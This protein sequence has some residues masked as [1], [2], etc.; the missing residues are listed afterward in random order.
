MIKT[1]RYP[2]LFIVGAPKSGT[3]SMAKYLST[4]PNIYAPL[5]KEFTYFG[6]DLVKYATIIEERQYLRWFEPWNDQYF[7]LDAS[8]FYL[9]SKTAPYEMLQKSPDAKFIIMLRKPSQ[10][11]YSM[12]FQ[13]LFGGGE[14]E[15]E[16]AK[17]WE[18]ERKRING[19]SIP[20]R[21]RLEFTT[22]YQSIGKYADYVKNYLKACGKDRVHIIF[23]EELKNSPVETYQKLLAFL[24]LEN[25]LPADFAVSNP[26]KKALFPALTRF[27]SSPPRWMGY[28]SSWILPKATRWKIRNFIKKKNTVPMEKPKLT[29]E[30]SSK[31]DEYFKS[32]VKQLEKLLSIDLSHWY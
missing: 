5:Q 28:A 20:K 14:D 9:Y 26:S 27:V 17:A 8:P 23:F 18:L 24:Q 22:R 32:D 30:M 3:T 25:H 31:L 19:R 29:E 1:P 11:A 6:E 7:G 15:K 21:A 4:H 12:Y 2:N 13:A 16:F 10:V